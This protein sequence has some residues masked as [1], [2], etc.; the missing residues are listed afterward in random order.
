M[1]PICGLDSLYD[2][3]YTYHTDDMQ[4]GNMKKLEKDTKRLNMVVAASWMDKIDNWRSKQPDLPNISESVRRL[5]DL[6]LEAS[7]RGGKHDR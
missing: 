7:K 3:Y 6:G 2:A 1:S 5:V 4:E